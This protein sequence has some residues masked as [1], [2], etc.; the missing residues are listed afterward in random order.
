MTYHVPP[1]IMTIE[2]EE[3]NTALIEAS[4]SYVTEDETNS[5]WWVDI[6]WTVIENDG[7]EITYDEVKLT[8]EKYL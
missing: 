2:D 5:D 1:T 3:G 6:S 8:L 7:V 4:G